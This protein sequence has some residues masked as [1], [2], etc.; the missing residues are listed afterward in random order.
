MVIKK[1]LPL[2]I[3]V[4]LIL[5]FGCESKHDEYIVRS[6]QVY[7]PRQDSTFTKIDTVNCKNIEKTKHVND[8]ELQCYLDSL[9]STTARLSE[10]G[11]EYRGIKLSET[12][13]K[14]ITF[15]ED[16]L[17][18]I[19]LHLNYDSSMDRD[20][21]YTREYGI[22]IDKIYHAVNRYLKNYK[23]LQGETLREEIDMSP[24]VE[25]VRQDTILSPKLLPPPGPQT[26]E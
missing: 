23:V 9:Y 11:T 16:K 26:N 24:L 13:Y 1:I 2:L 7:A 25:K 6:W 18:I 22:I 10:E 19:R 4:A 3:I 17:E 12:K 14:D 5:S 21:Y 20:V 8:V 15:N